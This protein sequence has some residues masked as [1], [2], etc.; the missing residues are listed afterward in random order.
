MNEMENFF[1]ALEERELK[2]GSMKLVS[3]EGTAILLIKQFGKIFAVD[4]R[5]PHQGCGFSGGTLDD[6]VIVCPCHEWRFNLE[7]GEYEEEPAFKLAKYEWKIKDGKI[8]VKLE[9]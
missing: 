8:W 7:S 6:G 1:P 3:V 4:N 9:D 5:C 2:D